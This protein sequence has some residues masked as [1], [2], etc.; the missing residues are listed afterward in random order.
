MGTNKYYLFINLVILLGALGGCKR[1]STQSVPDAPPPYPNFPV[2]QERYN[3]AQIYGG[4]PNNLPYI[5]P[6]S[7]SAA[8]VVNA[9]PSYYTPPPSLPPNTQTFQPK[10]TSNYAS[11]HFHSQPNFQQPNAKNARFTLEAN[12]ELWALVQDSKGV[13]LEWLKMKKGDTAALNHTGAL[14]IT[15]SSGDQLIIKDKNL[16]PVQTNP[17]PSGISIVRLPSL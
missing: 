16:K 17:N 15:C 9:T 3:S 14:T 1:S 4:Q 11:A 10:P 6:Y 2:P 12:A 7:D 8:G 13:E 5:P